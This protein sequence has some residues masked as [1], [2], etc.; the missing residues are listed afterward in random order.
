MAQTLADTTAR[1]SA[2]VM[3]R[4]DRWLAVV[5]IV[6]GLWF[7]KGILSKISWTLWAGVL[8]IP[9]VSERW[10]GFMPMRIAEWIESSPPE[11]YKDFLVGTVMPNSELFARL[12]AIG[13]ILVGIGVT[14]GLLTVL[15]SAGGLWLILNYA[16]ASLGENFNQQGLHVMLTACFLSFMGAR[17]GRTWGLDGWLVRQYPHSLLAR[18]LS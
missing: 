11:W 6:V 18:V 10:I 13:E 17:A 3:Q 9:S 14:F 12:T 15:F 8:P 7:L 1:R 2:V 16:V 5:R 4:S